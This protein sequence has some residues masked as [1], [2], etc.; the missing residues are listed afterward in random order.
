MLQVSQLIK[1]KA[2][3]YTLVDF[4]RAGT[5][6]HYSTPVILRVIFALMGRVD[7]QECYG[8]GY[9]YEKDTK[10]ELSSLMKNSYHRHNHSLS[11]TVC[12][13]DVEW[14]FNLSSK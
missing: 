12:V 11:L 14:A 1:G 7:E 3:I 2:Q 6:S 8:P 9:R 10:L 13:P 4:C 5:H